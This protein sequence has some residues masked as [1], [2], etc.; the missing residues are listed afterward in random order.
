MPWLNFAQLPSEDL[1]AIYAY[2][3]TQPAVYQW[4]TPI[5][6]GSRTRHVGTRAAESEGI[7]RS[8]PAP[9]V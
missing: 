5:R 4:W 3:R 8:R 2:L 1:K 7:E 6:C 9:T